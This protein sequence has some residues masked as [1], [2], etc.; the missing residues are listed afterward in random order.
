[1]PGTRI[2]V[3][4][5]L[6]GLSVTGLPIC[7]SKRQWSRSPDAKNNLKKTKKKWPM[8]RAISAACAVSDLTYRRRLKRS[9]TGRRPISCRHSAQLFSWPHHHN[10]HQSDEI[11]VV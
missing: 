11:N 10:H 5:P 3:N 4:V 6:Q 1:M 8:S 9:E 2:G 7:S